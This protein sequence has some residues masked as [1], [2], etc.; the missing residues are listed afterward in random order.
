MGLLTDLLGGGN[1]TSPLASGYWYGTPVATVV[2]SATS[3]NRLFL[4]PWMVE[5][6]CSIDTIRV[7]VTVG[8]ASALVRL[9]LYRTDPAT[10][11]PS[12][13]V[14]DFGTVDGNSVAVHNV[15]ISET[16][17]PGLHWLAVAT[18]G[19]APTMWCLANGAGAFSPSDGTVSTVNRTGLYASASG[20]LPDVPS[21]VGVIATPPRV[22][23]RVAA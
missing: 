15:S 12:G 6:A 5:K 20:A 13:L 8:A 16:L 10:G 9:G 22:L 1:A 21:V 2:E 19:G 11:L 17:T 4:T 14:G 23:V 3:S 18:Q 7:Q